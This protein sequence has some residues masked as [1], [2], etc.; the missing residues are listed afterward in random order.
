MASGGFTFDFSSA[1]PMLN[2][3]MQR[4]GAMMDLQQK[5][6]EAELTRAPQAFDLWK[7]GKESALTDAATSRT[8]A[9]EDQRRARERELAGARSAKASDLA[10]EL[11]KRRSDY[12]TGMSMSPRSLTSMGFTPDWGRFAK[13]EGA[14]M[15][16]TGSAGPS[17]YGFGAP[18]PSPQDKQYGPYDPENP[19]A[20]A[21][22]WAP[23]QR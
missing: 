8:M 13:P 21:A 1:M 14:V 16:D 9:L 20:D 6:A 11:A 5:G 7:R 18:L 2:A 23:A 22:L 4:Y 19:K 15:R 10:A 12:I 17:A 3:L